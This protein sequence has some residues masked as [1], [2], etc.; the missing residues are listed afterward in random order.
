MPIEIL[1]ISEWIGVSKKDTV[2]ENPTWEEVEGAVRALNNRNLNDLYLQPAR[3]DPETFLCIGGGDGRYLVSG[4]I[5]NEEFPTVVD[6]AKPSDVVEHLVVGGQTGDYAGNWIVDLET[7]L[8]AARSFFES[9][10]FGGD[11]Q[12]ERV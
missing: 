8:R 9:G 2:V 4:S 1:T 6:P 10:D 12:W 5:G 3:Q 7:A 11:V